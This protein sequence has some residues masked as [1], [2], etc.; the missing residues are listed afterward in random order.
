MPAPHAGFGSLSGYGS[1][2]PGTL[3]MVTMR[4]ARA[5]LPMRN[6]RKRMGF[7][8]RFTAFRA[9]FRCKSNIIEISCR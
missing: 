1:S 6:K 9:R 2:C 4:M 5:S 3:F 8:G 7:T